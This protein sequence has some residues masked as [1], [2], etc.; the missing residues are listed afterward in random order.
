MT[1]LIE[2]ITAVE[3]VPAIE[4][5]GIVPRRT[6]Y[7]SIW[8]VDESSLPHVYA[9]RLR[10]QR[11]HLIY[12]GIAAGQTLHER[13]VQQDLHHKKASSFFRSLGAALGFRP[14]R[15]SLVGMKNER[16][17]KFS[18]SD[19]ETIVNWIDSHLQVGIVEESPAHHETE[20]KAIAHLCP[21]LNLDYNP[22]RLTELIAARAECLEIARSAPCIRTVV[23]G[24]SRSR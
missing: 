9:E 18:P 24:R 13:L 15:G 8:V 6:G 21:V 2:R 11:T 12:V 17:Y 23:R 1:N 20:R 22:Q 5:A 14:L 10:Q 4:A 19:T 3:R 16:N 7:Y